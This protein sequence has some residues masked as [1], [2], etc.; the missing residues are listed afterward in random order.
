MS[1][2]SRNQAYLLAGAAC[3]ALALGSL[4]EA[5]DLKMPVKAA[6]AQPLFDWTGFYIGGHTGY[7]HGRS[8]SV[9]WDPAPTAQSGN[10]GLD[11]HR[12]LNPVQA[13]RRCGP[14][15]LLDGA[16]PGGVRNARPDGKFP[17][18][19]M[20]LLMFLDRPPICSRRSY[21]RHTA[22]H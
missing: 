3:G 13:R 22:D 8:S 17:S 12:K 16:D 21:R 7:S 2:V 15:A 6:Y 11:R 4:A 14:H 10:L 18:N 9:L 20:M 5:A 1:R 19:R